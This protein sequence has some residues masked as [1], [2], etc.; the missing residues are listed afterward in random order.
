MIYVM[1]QYCSFERH[2]SRNSLGNK[3]LNHQIKL[4]AFVQ[5][6]DLREHSVCLLQYIL[7]AVFTEYCIDLNSIVL[8]GKG[9]KFRPIRSE[10]TVLS[11]L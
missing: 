5:L 11:R 3:N 8:S 7:T 2:S 4:I 1:K 10:K 9:L 6:S